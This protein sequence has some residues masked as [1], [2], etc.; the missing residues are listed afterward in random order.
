MV[1]VDASHDQRHLIWGRLPL[2]TTTIATAI[3]IA[4]T[5]SNLHIQVHVHRFI[6]W[7]K[8]VPCDTYQLPRPLTFFSFSDLVIHPHSLSCR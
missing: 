5:I 6:P 4:I 2:S 8:V 3:Y 7:K 1:T